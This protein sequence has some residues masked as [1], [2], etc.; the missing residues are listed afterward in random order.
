MALAIILFSATPLIAMQQ[1]EQ[2]QQSNKSQTAPATSSSDNNNESIGE[3]ITTR[4][5]D[6]TALIATY[7]FFLCCS[8]C[9]NRK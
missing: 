4:I 3:K 5:A 6:C 7:T 1:Q 9:N 8:C 2:Q